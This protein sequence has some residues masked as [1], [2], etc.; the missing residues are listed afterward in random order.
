MGGRA[1]EFDRGRDADQLQRAHPGKFIGRGATCRQR[2]RSG[3][4]ENTEAHRRQS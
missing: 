3:V 2:P 1:V 4:C